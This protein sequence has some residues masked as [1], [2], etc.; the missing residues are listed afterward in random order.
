MSNTVTP[1]KKYDTGNVLNQAEVEK[2]VVGWSER[3]EVDWDSEAK[4][5]SMGSLVYFA[6]YLHSGG[7]LDR[8]CQRTPLEYISNNAP[9][10]RDVLGTLILSILNG[11]TRYA[12]INALRGD[13]VGAEVLGVSKV[14]SEDSVRR[15]LKRGTPEEWNKWL[16]IQERT[17][18]EPL[19]VEDYV[20]DIDNTVKPLYGNQEGAEIGY[21]PQKPGRPSHNY[22]TYFIG[23]LRIVLGV[24]VMQGK[25][26]AGKYS[27]TGLWNMIDTLPGECRPS[28]IRGDIGYGNEKIM[29]DCEERNQR[30]LFKLKQT[31]KVKK[32]ILR[33]ECDSDV[34]EDAGDGWQGCEHHL[35]LT[36][37]SCSRR[38]IFIRR[39]LKKKTT[40]KVIPETTPREFAFI[41]HLHSGPDYEYAVLITNS[42]L[43]IIAI[44]QLYRDRA[45]CENV[46]DEIKNQWGWAGF[47]T[48]DINRCRII[49][50][51]I[52]IIYNWWNIFTR[53]ANPDQH[54]EAIT[55]RP[56]LL[57]AVGRIVSTGRRKIIH[58]TSTHSK[59]NE[60]QCILTK[61][62]TFLNRLNRTAE[63]L[64]IEAR[65]AIILSA[66]FVKW[67]H[68]KILQPIVHGNQIL[69][70][71]HT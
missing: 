71:L 66:A 39:P 62:G 28:L 37:W 33:L 53:L 55:S 51:F 48:H 64:S 68:G 11:Q 2:L 30:Y 23:S 1:K 59:S 38:C 19:L 5:T 42:E 54:M 8:L 70:Q 52:A 15:A 35:K 40:R 10:E 50:R 6:Q 13:M 21:N 46:F 4:V 34:W 20:L 67:L 60:I 24:D 61:I 9:K 58:L 12:H 65:W 26:S 63:Q 17:V 47:V 36:G 44:T 18:Y 27:M 49:A 29:T 14:V 3:F 41:E 31:T 69:F 32:Q 22:H 43:S 56:L 7:L 45:D 16:T 25:K 57:Y